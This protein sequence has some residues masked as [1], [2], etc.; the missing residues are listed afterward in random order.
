[1]TPLQKV[2]NTLKIQ[3]DGWQE[4]K[5]Y[6]RPL[7]EAPPIIT[8]E[9]YAGVRLTDIILPRVRGTLEDRAQEFNRL[10]QVP[11]GQPLETGLPEAYLMNSLLR[12][13]FWAGHHKEANLRLDLDKGICMVL[14]AHTFGFADGTVIC[15]DGTFPRAF[16]RATLTTPIMVKTREEDY[17]KLMRK[18]FELGEPSAI[19]VLA[20]LRGYRSVHISKL[21]PWATK[22]ARKYSGPPS[23]WL[24]QII[25]QSPNPAAELYLFLVPK[26]I[27]KAVFLERVMPIEHWLVD[28]PDTL[29]AALWGKIE[30]TF[31]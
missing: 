3:L 25:M 11:E 28:P 22:N 29:R 19:R 14:G 2:S 10:V 1:M 13:A 6:K 4:V 7:V 17:N 12:Y 21:L 15:E 27:P 9:T 24:S 26:Y 5:G 8:D 30:N 31:R 16:D 18:A 23:D 20:A